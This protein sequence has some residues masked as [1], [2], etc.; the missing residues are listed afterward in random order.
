MGTY[1]TFVFEQIFV[2]GFIW[3]EIG[4]EYCTTFEDM[5]YCLGFLSGVLYGCPEKA[6]S[7]RC[8]ER[9]V[10][11]F[12]LGARLRNQREASTQAKWPMVGEMLSGFGSTRKQ[13]SVIYHFYSLGLNLLY[14]K[15]SSLRQDHT[16]RGPP[17]VMQCPCSLRSGR[18][19]VLH[20]DFCQCFLEAYVPAHT[21]L[22]VPLRFPNVCQAVQWSEGFE[23]KPQNLRGCRIMGRKRAKP[24]STMAN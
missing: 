18:P 15:D 7:L 4:E 10:H 3:E 17:I 16:Q 11:I 5:M 12:G 8:P 9:D 19:Q 1:S 23:D 24:A 2:E 13:I 20:I 21:Y 22:H 6:V 14:Q